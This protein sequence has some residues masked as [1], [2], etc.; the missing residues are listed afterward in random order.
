MRGVVALGG[1]V[2]ASAFRPMLRCLRLPGFGIVALL[3]PQLA[4]AQQNPT[5]P[6]LPEIQV[7][8]T[9]P[10]PPVRRAAGPASRSSAGAQVPPANLPPA[11]PSAPAGEAGGVDRDK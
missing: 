3:V 8:G 5:K 6:T 10:L 11:A 2:G 1:S 7:I 4:F 9:T